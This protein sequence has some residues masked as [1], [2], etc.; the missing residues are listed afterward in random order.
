[1]EMTESSVVRR[2]KNVSREWFGT[3][4]GTHW[5]VAC[6]VAVI[7]FGG[8]VIYSNRDTSVT[9]PTVASVT[10]QTPAPMSPT[11]LTLEK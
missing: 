9:I 2:S 1:M 6:S 8:Y 5:G 7:I 4:R 11:P 10:E 3:K